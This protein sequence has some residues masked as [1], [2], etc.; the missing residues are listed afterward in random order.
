MA[1]PVH[2]DEAG[3]EPAEALDRLAGG[4]W[5]TY[6]M[7]GGRGLQFR[8]EQFLSFVRMHSDPLRELFVGGDN[9]F[10]EITTLLQE[11]HAGGEPD[12]AS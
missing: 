1:P 8:Y 4:C 7:P 12:V 9:L 10:R 5:H 3:P 2:P 6:P 11:F